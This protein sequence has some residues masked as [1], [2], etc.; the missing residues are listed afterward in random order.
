[1]ISTGRYVDRGRGNVMCVLLRW[2]IKSGQNVPD[3]DKYDMRDYW[4]HIDFYEKNKDDFDSFEE[5]LNYYFN[6]GGW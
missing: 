6:H 4:D 2:L 1:M 5:A 3:D